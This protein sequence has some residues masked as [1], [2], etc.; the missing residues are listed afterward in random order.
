[1]R[2]S[3]TALIVVAVCLAA[4]QLATAMPDAPIFG[5]LPPKLMNAQMARELRP[6][7][8]GPCPNETT[9]VGF[10]PGYAS[11]N[12]WSIGVGAR[13]PNS[14][15]GNSSYGYWGWDQAPQGDSLQGW[16]PV[17]HPYTSTGGRTLPDV[18]RPW[19]ALDIG[20]QVNYVINQGPGQRRT[21]GVVGV[22]HVDP[23]A[24]L[25]PTIPGTN[26]V[27]PAW[28]PLIGAQSAWCGL[29]AHGDLT[30]IDPITGNP[31][32]VAAMEQTAQN[33]DAAMGTDRRYPG[34]GSQWDQM[35]Y[36]D[37]DITGAPGPLLTL[38]FNVQTAMSTGKLSFA[39]TRT[40]WFEK[41]P[42]SMAPGNYIPSVGGAG[43]PIDAFMVYIGLPVGDAVGALFVGSDGL[44]HSVFDPQRRWLSEVIRVNES[45]AI[46]FVKL[47]T[48]TGNNPAFPVIVLATPIAPFLAVTPKIRVVFR[49]KTNRGFDDDGGSYCSYSSNGMG[50]A[51][52]DGVTINLGAGAIPIGDFEN[53]GDIDNDLSTSP[54]DAWKSTGKPP[55]ILPHVHPLASLVYQ[56]VC[57][58]PGSAQRVCN[59]DGNVISAGDHDNGEAIGGFSQVLPDQERFDGIYSPTINLVTP[60]SGSPATPNAQGITFNMTSNADDYFAA[61]EVYSGVTDLPNLGVG[62]QPYFQCYPATQATSP[63]GGFGDGVRCWGEFRAPQFMYFNPTP[64]CFDNL[65]PA[66]MWGLIRT[67]N[68]NLKPDSL[69]IGLR[70]ITECYRFAISAD[71]GKP[72]GLY[73]DNVS[74]AMISGCQHDP[75]SVDIWHWI[76]DAFPFNTNPALPGLAAF[77]TTTAVIKTGLNTAPE[78]G[79]MG[80]C[81]APGDYV[82][83]IDEGHNVRV[84]MVFRIWPGPGNYVALGNPAS[85]LRAIPTSPVAIA[86]GDGSFWTSYILFNG[87]RGA[88][89]GHPPGPHATRWDPLVWNSAQCDTPEAKVFPVQGRNLYSGPAIGMFAATYHELDPRYVPLGVPR[90][91][92]FMLNPNGDPSAITCAAV[93]AWVTLPAG[94][95]PFGWCTGYDGLPNTV[96]GTKIIPDG[97]LTP[98]SHVEYFFVREDIGKAGLSYC[99]DTTIV[100]PQK[101]EGPSTD[102]HRWQE[103]GV[104]PDSWKKTAYGGLGQ[105]CM[106][107]VD[108]ADR[109]GNERTWAGTADSL[110]ATRPGKWGAHNGWHAN[111]KMPPD[112]PVDPNDPTWFVYDK[113]CQPGTTWDM[114]GV[115]GAEALTANANSLGARL[116]QDCTPTFPGSQIAPTP[117]MLETY[118]RILLVLTGDISRLIL[119]PFNDKSQDDAGIIQRFLQ[120]GTMFE[121]RG[122]FTEGE[123]FVEAAIGTPAEGVVLPML[124]VTLRDPAYRVVSANTNLC[125]DIVTTPVITTNGD[126]YGVRNHCIFRNNVLDLSGPTATAATFYQPVGPAPPYISGVFHDVV[127]PEYWQALTDGW[128][129]ENL[130]GRYCG[131]TIGRLAYFYK[132]LNNIFGKICSVTGAPSSI[133]DVPQNDDGRLFV[134]SVSVRNNP[135]VS[136]EA[137]LAFALAQSDRVAARIYDV[138]G[139]LVRT[140]ADQRFAAGE[141]RLAWDGFDDHGR[142][143]ARGVYFMR[144]RYQESGFASGKQLVLLR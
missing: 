10:N 112:A 111:G 46:P 28:A 73:W 38:S 74:L 79:N 64:Q 81:D 107:Y 7:A 69:R 94:C 131:S 115:K 97:L 43:D 55:G 110:S 33:A 130:L 122:I 51:Q 27:A 22:W 66:R 52:L 91:K 93:P 80:R 25:G 101:S 41:D 48:L 5:D 109:R 14:G 31:F 144:V 11:S 90:H 44:A 124:G 23:G 137:T 15:G 106:L 95:L 87:F 134:N 135:V 6:G 92:C 39:A 3:I 103:F 100:F 119:G 65:D 84:D 60:G 72:D 78:T 20:N 36:R 136:G 133:L 140:L 4:T 116:A 56:D 126:I 17:R 63:P 42:L 19:W 18:S 21:M 32:N 37:I 85:G 102:A 54:L 26:P 75:V 114:Y 61:Y 24:V 118:Y 29:R 89:A 98:G 57:G 127:V 104:L 141:H 117:S 139:R 108:W 12:Y 142:S 70:S 30:V 86:P 59:M 67:S 47:L 120:S 123:G 9:Y 40:G 83:G 82:I 34:Y 96:E 58:P 53:W 50:A 125:A 77:D 76:N 68:S 132:A 13:R 143:V 129:I 99:P 2:L 16:W 35:L 62:W 1:M 71:C 105:A 113:N 45:P 121:H 8:P 49:L 128:D 138:S 88:P